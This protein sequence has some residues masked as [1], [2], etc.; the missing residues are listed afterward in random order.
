MPFWVLITLFKSAA[1]TESLFAPVHFMF[2]VRSNPQQLFLI[3]QFHLFQL[4][5][6]L[7]LCFVHFQCKQGYSFS[8]KLA[9]GLSLSAFNHHGLVSLITPLCGCISDCCY[10][11]YTNQ[12]KRTPKKWTNQRLLE[13]FYTLHF[14]TIN[15]NKTKL[16]HC[17]NKRVK[18]RSL[19]Q[20]WLIKEKRIAQNLGRNWF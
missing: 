8:N 5:V 18:A 2:H 3:V 6:L 11:M 9:E 16:W 19:T 4:F 12:V 20:R 17:G 10:L 14:K 7:W 15:N 13:W 1:I